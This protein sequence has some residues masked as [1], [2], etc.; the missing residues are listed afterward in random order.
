[1]NTAQ[2]HQVAETNNPVKVLG[3]WWD[4]GSDLIYSSHKPIAS[5]TTTTTK[6]DILKWA[7]TIF[8]PLGLI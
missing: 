3:L 1:M 8:D 7:S 2:E 6:R 5:V 4:T